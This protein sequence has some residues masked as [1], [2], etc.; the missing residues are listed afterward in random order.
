MKLALKTQ[1]EKCSQH[2][3][4][5][6]PEEDPMLPVMLEIAKLEPGEILLVYH[7]WESPAFYEVWSKRPDLEW[8]A[9]PVGLN[10]WLIWVY[11]QESTAALV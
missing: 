1:P 4:V 9:E 3:L 5:I 6:D 2:L 8:Y 7:H 11:C 10:E